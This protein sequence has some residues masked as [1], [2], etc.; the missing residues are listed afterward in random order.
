MAVISVRNAVP[1]VGVV[2]PWES[3]PATEHLAVFQL[4]PGAGDRAADRRGASAIAG[5]GGSG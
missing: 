1:R 3:S 2:A 4:G 5:N